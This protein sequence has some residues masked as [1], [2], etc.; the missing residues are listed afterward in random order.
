MW[1]SNTQLR[2]KTSTFSD[3]K[4]E[5]EKQTPCISSRE[6]IRDRKREFG[7]IS[8]FPGN[9][10]QIGAESFCL[11][12]SETFLAVTLW[13]AVACLS[14]DRKVARGRGVAHG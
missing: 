6:V 10:L 4:E 3:Q 8:W 7:R 14:G 1:F 9:E 11:W 13:P 2:E 5:R 12:V